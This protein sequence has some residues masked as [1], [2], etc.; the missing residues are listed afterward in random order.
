MAHLSDLPLREELRGKS[1]YGAPQ[2]TVTNQLN[3]NENPYPPSDAIIAE[4]V[5][6]VEVLGRDTSIVCTHPAC[7]TDT[8]RAVIRSDQEVDP[9]SETVRFSLRPEK[10]FLF[11]RSTEE[12]LYGQGAGPARP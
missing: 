4:F 12:R 2:L 5:T 1:A 3:T 10:V 8:L 9:D 6:R 11:D 7:Q